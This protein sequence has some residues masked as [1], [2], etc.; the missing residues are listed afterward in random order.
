ME[1]LFK[2]YFWIVK[3]LGLWIAP[4]PSPPPSSPRTSAPR[5][6]T[7]TR[8]PTPWRPATPATARATTTTTRTSRSSATLAAPA[9]SPPPCSS[10]GGGDRTKLIGAVLSRNLFC[11]TCAKVEAPP[12]TSAGVTPS[13]RSPAS[14]RTSAAVRSPARSRAPCRCAWWRPWRPATASSRGPRCATRRPAAPA[15]TG[16]ATGSTPCCPRLR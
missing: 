15:P 10:G 1:A 2:Q 5:T 8:T 14:P 6:S 12:D 16:P 3:G 7:T 4:R 11:P 9:A 13:T